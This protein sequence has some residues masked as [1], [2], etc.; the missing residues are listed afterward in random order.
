MVEICKAQKDLDIKDRPGSAPFLDGSDLGGIHGDPI[1][2]NNETKESNRGLVK[3]ALLKFETD[4]C[5]LEF[6]KDLGDV[7]I[8]FLLGVRIDQNVI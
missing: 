4:T 1:N 6:C 8:M 2:T 3:L 7:G 5:F